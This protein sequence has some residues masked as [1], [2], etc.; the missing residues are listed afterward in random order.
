M[1]LKRI[2]LLIYNDVSKK[3][4][5]E[6]PLKNI[7]NYNLTSLEQDVCPSIYEGLEDARDSTFMTGY[8]IKKLL[9]MENRIEDVNVWNGTYLTP[10]FLSHFDV[11]GISD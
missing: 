9:A 5:A 2:Y 11:R 7:S 10:Q 4:K 3:V 1:C 8:H 6:Y